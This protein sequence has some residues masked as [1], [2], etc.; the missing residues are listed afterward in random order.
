[1]ISIVLVN[2]FSVDLIKNSTAPFYN[3]SNFQIIVVDNSFETDELKTIEANNMQIIESDKNLGFGAACNKGIQNSSGDYILFLNPD[4]FISKQNVI[5]L[6]EFLKN[7]KK[8][9]VSPS[10]Y[11]AENIFVSP[12][13]HPSPF[14]EIK[15]Q[16]AER[17]YFLNKKISKAYTKKTFTKLLNIKKPMQVNTL[18]GGCFMIHKSVIKCMPYFFDED[19]FMYFEDS[20]LFLRLKSKGYKLFLLPHIKVIHKSTITK[21]K[22]KLMVKSQKI[23]IQKNYDTFFYRFIKKFICKLNKLKTNLPTTK[24]NKFPININRYRNT[25]FIQISPT[26]SF[27]PFL[28]FEITDKNKFDIPTNVLTILNEG[29]FYLRFLDRHFNFTSEILKFKL[30]N[31]KGFVLKN[32]KTH[33]KGIRKLFMETFDNPMTNE[34]WNWKYGNN[35]GEAIVAISNNE[36]IAHYGGIK[37]DILY[38][39]QKEKAIQVCDV[40]VNIS[41]RGNLQKGVFFSMATKFLDNFI[42]FNSPSLLGY[43]FPNQ[44]LTKLANKLNIYQKVGKII[45]LKFKP[46]ENNNIFFTMENFDY[47]DKHIQIIN[48]IWQKIKTEYKQYIIGIRDYSYINYRYLQH[49]IYTYKVI[50]VKNTNE[51]K[52]IGIIIYKKQ[53]QS[54]FILDIIACQQDTKQVL[55]TFLNLDNIQNA[56]AIRFWISEHFSK[57]FLLENTDILDIK[58][59]IPINIW[60]KGPD[61]DTLNEKWYLTAGDS[62][63]N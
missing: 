25:H 46:F 60:S 30:K 61:F 48:T 56:T 13:K 12:V 20:D 62:D 34:F 28:G 31:S 43:G 42:G 14:F 36:V 38:F 58:I 2:Y 39:G 21:N 41:S 44:R 26:P 6:K 8:S 53:E 7:N 1:M 29:T 27:F 45:E 54:I 50:L 40:M 16:L 23:F 57:A 18:S 10:L 55:N 59:S 9:I 4:A 51:N 17:K 32:G 3:D 11:I 33:K 22:I 47:S 19:Y 52:Y 5:M 35:K 49:P 37:R 63:F 15:Q 24:I